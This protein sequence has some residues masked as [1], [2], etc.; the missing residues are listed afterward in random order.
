VQVIA[1]SHTVPLLTDRK[2]QIG[3]KSYNY[4]NTFSYL[5]YR[6]AASLCGFKQ[7]L[8][9]VRMRCLV[10]LSGSLISLTEFAFIRGAHLAMKSKF[11]MQFRKINSDNDQKNDFG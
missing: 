7:G 5:A 6:Q 3:S 8:F 1:A 11:Q 9:P 2:A 10:S 4:M